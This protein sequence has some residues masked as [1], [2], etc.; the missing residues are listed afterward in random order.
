MVNR[1][2]IRRD[3]TAA[4]LPVVAEPANMYAVGAYVVVPDAY[5]GQVL[6]T[7]GRIVSVQKDTAEA[8]MS[9]FVYQVT[10]VI[11]GAQAGVLIP[12]HMMGPAPDFL[13]QSAA[14]HLNSVLDSLQAAL[15]DCE[16]SSTS[17]Y[18]PAEDE[19]AEEADDIGEDDEVE[20]PRPNRRPLDDE[21]DD[22]DDDSVVTWRRVFPDDEEDRYSPSNR[23]W[24][25]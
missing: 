20:M 21:Y 18:I 9:L 12:E 24:G 14:D 22:L 25:G 8:A 2:R 17:S 19:D 13:L 16:T 10:Y 4:A 1:I 7:L 3:P 5:T 15:D 23:S 6:S 11:T